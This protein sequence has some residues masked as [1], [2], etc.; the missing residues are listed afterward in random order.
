MWEI[1]E[2]AKS[3]GKDGDHDDEGCVVPRLRL[4]EEDDQ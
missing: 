3:D 1:M 4:P 2:S